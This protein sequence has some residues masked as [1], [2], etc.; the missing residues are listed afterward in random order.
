[1][2]VAL[3]GEEGRDKRRKAAARG[4]YPHEPPMSEWGN[5]A[6]AMP[7]RRKSAGRTRGTE[8]SQYPQEKKITM[9]PRVVASESGGA[10]TAGVAMRRAGLQDR[11]RTGGETV[12]EREGKR[13]RRG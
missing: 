4:K 3:G 2:P 1:M 13:G 6:A 7:S 11:Q 8:T 9:I 5:P 12:G 10:Q